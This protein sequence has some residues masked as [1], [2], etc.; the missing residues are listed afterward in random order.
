[1]TITVDVKNTGA[2]AGKEVAELYLSA[3]AVK[4]DKPTMELKG[5]AKTKLLKPGESQ[6]LSFTID[7]HKPCFIRYSNFFMDC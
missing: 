6:T 2:V 5:F 7:S 4:L 3:P 1:M